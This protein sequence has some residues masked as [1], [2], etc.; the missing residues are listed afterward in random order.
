MRYNC[1]S[2]FFSLLPSRRSQLPSTPLFSLL[3]HERWFRVL[4]QMGLSSFPLSPS[5]DDKITPRYIRGNSG[6]EVNTGSPP[7]L[8]PSHPNRV[9]GSSSVGLQKEKRK[10]WRPIDDALSSPLKNPFIFL[11]SHPP[12]LFCCRCRRRPSSSSFQPTNFIIRAEPPVPPL[13]LSES[14][15]GRA[16]DSKTPKKPPSGHLRLPPPP[17]F[18]FLLLRLR[19]RQ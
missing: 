2:S 17:P 13:F 9:G 12:P 16:D 8:L 18:F 6:G 10:R 11:A 15:G 5:A 1:S 4:F 3:L 7:L 14:T 19:L